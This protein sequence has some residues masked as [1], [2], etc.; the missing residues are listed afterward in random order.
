M[1]KA[2]V[3]TILSKQLAAFVA[4]QAEREGL[5]AAAWLRRLVQAEYDRQQAVNQTREDRLTRLEEDAASLNTWRMNVELELS[6]LRMKQSRVTK[7]R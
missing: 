1:K 3:Q 4:K 6:E 5:S 7:K 2:L